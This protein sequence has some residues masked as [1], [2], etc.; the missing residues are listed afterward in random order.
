M[1]TGWSCSV[2][3]GRRARRRGRSSRLLADRLHR[4]GKKVSHATIARV[5]KHFGIQP[6]RSAT[7]KFSTDPELEAKVRDIVGL[8]LDPPE[9]AVVL[10]VGEKTQIQALDRTAPI[11]PLRPGLPEKRAHDYEAS[12]FDAAS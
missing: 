8:Y 11:L 6:H 7:F 1:S 12:E 4:E 10:C 5:W 9:W 2:G 3:C